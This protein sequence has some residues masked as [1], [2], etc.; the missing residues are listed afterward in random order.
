MMV[1]AS[2]IYIHIPFCISKCAYCDF[3]SVPKQNTE[4]RNIV[5]DNY[6]EALCNEI[7]YRIRFYKISE[8]KT[9]YIGGGTPS[10]LT[11]NQF[12][13]LF[14]KI[15][16]FTK[17]LPDAEITVEVNPDDVTPE[18]LE[19]L[20]QCGVNR[21]SCGL[22]S[23]NELA[24][25][26]ACRRADLDTN[27]KALSLIKE[28]WKGD[29]SF[30]LISGLPGEDEKSLVSGLKEVISY[31]PSHISLYSLTI[32]EKTP[33]G[34]QLEAGLLNYDFDFADKLW[35][36]GRNFLEQ[37]GYHWYEVSNFCK[38][39]KEC[40]HNL[41]Y[42]THGGYI[43]C[44]SGACG[45]VYTE[46]GTG[47][48]WTNTT[49]IDEYILQGAKTQITENIDLPTSQFEF[50]MMGL[51][52]LKGICEDDY[53]A[54]FGD[55]LPERF[56]SLFTKWEKRGLCVRRSGYYAMS[57]EGI[58]FLNRFLEELCV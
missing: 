11:T 39:R 14:S 23:M 44:G 35:L 2:A 50:F 33:F 34:K 48:R 46:A 12:Q 3:F 32:E 30:D 17:V 15:K 6:L 37:N 10:L 38:N 54:V 22:Q 55:E 21:I 47:V 4:T 26:K 51:R 8:L 18:L 9:I 52:K 40:L 41:V 13:K 1:K 29:A 49:D 25:K 45:T 28:Y 16:S 57:R 5:P 43:G 27:R 56:V 20:W 24:L 58:L 31:N 42:W 53:K 7:A 36:S 19:C